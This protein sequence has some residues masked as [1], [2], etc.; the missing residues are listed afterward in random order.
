MELNRFKEELRAAKEDLSLPSAQDE[1]V[2]YEGQEGT[3]EH[4]DEEAYSETMGYSRP[5]QKTAAPRI[6]PSRGENA[7]NRWGKSASSSGQT[8]KPKARRKVRKRANSGARAQ[9]A[10]PD[11]DQLEDVDMGNEDGLSEKFSRLKNK[12]NVALQR[13]AHQHLRD[14]IARVLR[15]AEEQNRNISKRELASL[16]MTAQRELKQRLQEVQAGEERRIK[17][18]LMLRD[19]EWSA[20]MSSELEAATARSDADIATKTH[21][22]EHKLTASKKALLSQVEEH[23]SKRWSAVEGQLLAKITAEAEE[24]QMRNSKVLKDVESVAKEAFDQKKRELKE[25]LNSEQ[26]KQKE[27]LQQLLSEQ[28][29]TLLEELRGAYSA[30]GEELMGEIKEEKLRHIEAVINK[31]RRV[32]EQQLDQRKQQLQTKRACA[33]TMQRTEAAFTT[34]L[35]GFILEYKEADRIDMEEYSRQEELKHMQ[36]VKE[37]EEEMAEVMTRRNHEMMRELR[38]EKEQEMGSIR[39]SLL[40]GQQQALKELAQQLEV[41]RANQ[42]QHLEEVMGVEQQELLKNSREA[43][44]AANAKELHAERRRF[45][46][47]SGA[48][49]D[50]LRNEMERLVLLGPKEKVGQAEQTSSGGGTVDGAKDAK[51]FEA[52]LQEKVSLQKLREVVRELVEQYSALHGTTCSKAKSE[53]TL[54]HELALCRRQMA[55]K[56]GLLVKAQERLSSDSRYEFSCR[57]LFI[58]NQELM[59]RIKVLEGGVTTVVPRHAPAGIQIGHGSTTGMHIGHGSAYISRPGSRPDSRGAMDRAPPGSSRPGSRPGSGMGAV[60][61]L[62]AGRLGR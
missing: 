58:A 7:D 52:Q 10:F 18:Q 31:E 54:A 6:H 29:S 24:H 1:G 34:L 9:A 49:V 36:Q 51:Y 13:F 38:V 28:E 56:E 25:R 32:L 40:N 3:F 61:S 19:Q 46:E 48:A 39:A 30:R 14:E 4:G 62:D 35:Q 33:S 44:I 26:A 60:S 2:Y 47:V 5:K 37:V 11:Y 12:G 15:W 50:K 45:Q 53:A 55:M 20:Q 8:G 22:L 57:K 43:I 17:K 42:L 41:D 27:Q 59:K 23:Q 21:Q 16:K